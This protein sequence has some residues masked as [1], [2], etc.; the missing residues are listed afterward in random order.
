MTRRCSMFCYPP[1]LPRTAKME[2]QATAC[3][4]RFASELED[5]WHLRISALIDKSFWIVI[6]KGGTNDGAREVRQLRQ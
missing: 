3:L 6:R 2:P 1:R 4:T 5:D